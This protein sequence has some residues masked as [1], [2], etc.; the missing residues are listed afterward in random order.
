MPIPLPNLDDR[1]WA[2]L[3]EEGRS[4]IPL[5]A[6]EWTDHNAS[7]PGI[8]LLELFAWIAEMDIYRINRIPDRHKLK[9][10]SLAGVSPNPPQAARAALSFQLKAPATKFDLPAGTECDGADPNGVDT[11]FCTLAALTVMDASMQSVV[12]FDSSVY[13]DLTGRW[14]RGEALNPMGA[15]PAVGA[16]LYLGF[17]KPLSTADW[18]SLYFLTGTAGQ[19]ATPHHSAR[20]VWEYLGAGSQWLAA[21]AQDGTRSLTQSGGVRL[22]PGAMVNGSVGP[23]KTPLYYVRA[24]LSGGQYDAAPA[25]L[26]IAVNAVEAEQSKPVVETWPLAA[27]A[28]VTGTPPA[29]GD[30][31]GLQAVFNG[32]GQVT[33]LAF[34]STAGSETFLVLNYLPG[35]SVT[36][37]ALRAGLGTGAP[38][39]TIALPGAP[40]VQASLTLY[41][42]ENGAWVV[43]T[44]VDDFAASRAGDSN[45][46]L[47][48]TTGTVTFGD[49][50]L[51]RVPPLNARIVAAYRTTRGAAGNVAAGAV[52]QLPAS[53][54]ASLASVTNPGAAAGGQD[55]ETLAHT[56]G[57]AIELREASLR[58]VTEQDYETLAIQT[59]GTRIARVT[60]IANVY[61]GFDCMRAPGVVTV[62][63][64]PSLPAGQPVPSAGLRS[65]VAA[66]LE[67]RRIVGTRVEVTGP[68][69]LEV[70][71]QATVGAFPTANKTQLQQAIVA[72]LNAFLDPLTGGPDKTGWPFGRDVYRTEIMSAIAQVPGVDRVE[73]LGLL[74]DGCGPMC[75]NLCLKPSWLVT[76]GSHRILVA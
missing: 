11:A 47:D 4:L 33:S 74:A 12:S 68:D 59:P 29:P 21:Q 28:V 13:V 73:S 76:P 7:D 16:S 37:Q 51:G 6:P 22:K 9:F 35:S 23:V 15:A 65:A 36:V 38:S 52:S 18:T 46:L 75:G 50:A 57:R 3:V 64:V 32:D 2:D 60:A 43:W 41:T 55:A 48:A 17:D 31:A 40:L 53:A 70:T 67:A 71:V 8:T 19:L 63:L 10:L 62:L 72:A 1:R 25:A 42:N 54:Q 14:N 45:Y 5:Y 30:S 69:Y 44:R 58:A 26:G 61:P 66:Y 56:I 27:G 20:V 24:R 34:G 39:L 49:G